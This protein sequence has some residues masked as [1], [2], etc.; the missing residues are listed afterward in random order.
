MELGLCLNS[1]NATFSPSVKWEELLLVFNETSRA[2]RSV[3]HGIWHRGSTQQVSP[4]LITEPC[5]LR[6]FPMNTGSMCQAAPF[7]LWEIVVKCRVNN[8]E[9]K[10]CF[11]LILF[12]D[13]VGNFDPLLM[14]YFFNHQHTSILIFLPSFLLPPLIQHIPILYHKPCDLVATS[15]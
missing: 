6:L 14:P 7:S 11:P 4:S 1:R 8:G 13:G 3:W 12:Q 5:S 15:H 10:V 2:E 9:R